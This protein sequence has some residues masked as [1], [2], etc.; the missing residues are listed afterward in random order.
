MKDIE[1]TILKLIY[2]YG[3]YSRI[4][5]LNAVINEVSYNQ[6]YKI[7]SGLVSNGYLEVMKF[8]STS[9][10]E[11]NTYKITYKTCA[12]F[13]DNNSF[14][15]KEHSIATS[16][17]YLIMNQFSLTYH[18]VL[19]QSLQSKLSDKVA[20][21]RRDFA[22]ED[23]PNKTIRGKMTHIFEEYIIDGRRLFE[24]LIDY[25]DIDISRQ[26][27]D[28]IVVAFDKPDYPPDK[29]VKKTINTFSAMLE[30]TDAKLGFIF[31][32]D[33]T[34]RIEVYKKSK[35]HLNTRNKYAEISFLTDFIYN[36]MLLKGTISELH[37]QDLIDFRKILISNSKNQECRVD[38]FSISNFE[39]QIATLEYDYKLNYAKECLIYCVNSSFNFHLIA[40]QSTV[41]M[42]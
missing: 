39:N 19:N 37:G 28:Y 8:Q 27:Y 41:Y 16:F 13:G 33:T 25:D 7:L 12:L 29:F 5:H 15:R 17:R 11:S 3:G 20:L 34:G 10:R 2:Q 24:P 6:L 40:N 26:S 23:I 32:F 35:V 9:S 4:Y 31:V 18:E 38:S 21:L 42:I 1:Y 22:E 14:L 30:N 36:Q